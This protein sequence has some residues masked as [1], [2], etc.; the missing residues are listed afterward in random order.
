MRTRLHQT[1][2]R[3]QLEQKDQVF[4][5]IKENNLHEVIII[6]IHK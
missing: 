1:L 2:K 3:N 6:T 5:A 4:S